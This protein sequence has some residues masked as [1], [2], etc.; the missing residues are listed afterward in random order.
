M[1]SDYNALSDEKTSVSDYPSNL[2]K[3]IMKRIRETNKDTINDDFIMK[4]WTSLEPE[5]IRASNLFL[6]KPNTLVR[7]RMMLRGIDLGICNGMSLKEI[8]E[9]HPDE[10]SKY[11]SSAY[12]YRFPRGESYYD[13]STRLEAV[14]M[15]LEREEKAVLIIA[16]P[17]VLRCF[18]A[19]IAL[20]PLSRRVIPS[21]SFSHAYFIELTPT[22]YGCIEKK[23]PVF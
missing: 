2:H 11:I 23:F 3:A 8:K 20:A 13:L 16:S 10:Y 5:S 19:Y 1:H 6:D 22:A 15:D 9:K 14:M 4:V 21:L 7:N 17:S 18:Y 12:N